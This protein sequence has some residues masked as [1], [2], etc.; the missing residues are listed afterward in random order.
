MASTRKRAALYL[1]VST[2]EQT[3]EN[4]RRELEAVAERSGWDVVEVYEDHGISGAKGRD[5]RPA[6]DKLM[7]DATRRRFDIVAAWA[8]DRVGRSV[9]TVSAIM[10]ELEDLGVGQYYHQQAI[11]TT[12]VAGR[13]MVQMCTVFAEFESG[14]MRERIKAGMARAKAESPKERKKKGK[15]AIG[16]PKVSAKIEEAIKAARAEGKG[17]RKIAREVGVGTGTVQRLV[18]AAA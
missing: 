17:I 9:H 5:K 10:A 8:I 16:R 4:Q 6:L 7:K 15:K 13:A 18:G 2:D 11:D 1:R 14:I 12:T 3:T